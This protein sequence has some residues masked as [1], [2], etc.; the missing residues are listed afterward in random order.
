VLLQ[1]VQT[2]QRLTSL[3]IS[4][5]TYR[6]LVVCGSVYISTTKRKEGGQLGKEGGSSEPPGYTPGYT[7][8][9]LLAFVLP[10]GIE[11]NASKP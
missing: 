1:H 9:V 7:P 5:Y 3:S 11:I 10:T 2:L 6:I 8:A 4:Y